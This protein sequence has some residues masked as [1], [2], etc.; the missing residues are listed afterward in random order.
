MM[1][2][3]A[4]DK[5]KVAVC[6]HWSPL[7]ERRVRAVAGQYLDIP[8]GRAAPSAGSGRKMPASPGFLKTRDK[9]TSARWTQVRGDRLHGG[10]T[11]DTAENAAGQLTTGGRRAPF[12]LRDEGLGALSRLG[13]SVPRSRGDGKRGRSRSCRRGK[14]QRYVPMRFDLVPGRGGDGRDRWSGLGGNPTTRRFATSRSAGGSGRHP[15]AM[16]AAT[17]STSGALVDEG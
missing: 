1:S 11:T 7:E 17:P 4:S 16:A 15:G 8:P 14:P 12:V 10:P 5:E 6:G 2:G 3:S 13:V 9:R